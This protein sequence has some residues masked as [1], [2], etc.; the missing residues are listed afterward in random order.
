MTDD[1][2]MERL[3]VLCDTK[4]KIE[5]AQ[6]VLRLEKKVAKLE[7]QVLRLKK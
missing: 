7:K 6:M 1:E 2:T 4:G 5:L 3:G